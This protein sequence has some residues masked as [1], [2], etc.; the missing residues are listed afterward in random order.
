MKGLKTELTYI[1]MLLNVATLLNNSGLLEPL[2][3]SC[4]SQVICVG[5]MQTANTI[6]A[7]TNT[8][9]IVKFLSIRISTDSWESVL[10]FLLHRRF[11]DAVSL[12]NTSIIKA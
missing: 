5:N 6:T 7:K 4:H 2:P 12:V 9:T 10:L 11:K 8:L 3:K 1:R